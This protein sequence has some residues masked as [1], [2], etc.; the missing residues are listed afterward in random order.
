[1]RLNVVKSMESLPRQ[2]AIDK[3]L[4]HK[5]RLS[6]VLATFPFTELLSPDSLDKINAGKP[7][8]WC[9]CTIFVSISTRD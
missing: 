3:E 5:I 1:M 9:F 4:P 7:I 2:L 6:K 8:K